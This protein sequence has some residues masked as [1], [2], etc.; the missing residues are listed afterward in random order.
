M[1]VP[2]TIDEMRMLFNISFLFLYLSCSCMCVQVRAKALKT[3]N[4]AHT[5][6]PRSTAFPVED[7][8]R[9]LMFRDVEEA[10]DF[11]QQYGLNVSEE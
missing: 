5:V 8:A 3:L 1:S 2:L 11:M 7:V 6:G 10:N 4:I 9:M